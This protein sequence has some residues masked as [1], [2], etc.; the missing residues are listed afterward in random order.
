M[1]G[2]KAVAPQ[3]CQVAI[4]TLDARNSM[5]FYTALL[6]LEATGH[7]QVQ[8]QKA[9]DLF[10]MPQVRAVNHW[11][12][13][14]ERF[15]QL[16]LF[17]FAHS[18]R[19]RPAPRTEGGYARLFVGVDEIGSTLTR[20]AQAGF[21]QS[22]NAAETECVLH[23]PDGT[24]VH[25]TPGVAVGAGARIVGVGLDVDDLDDALR[26]FNQALGLPLL[27][28]VPGG[29]GGTRPEG[30]RLDAGQHWIE[31]RH[32]PGVGASAPLDAPGLMNIALGL[33][34]PGQFKARYRRVLACGFRS[35]T[36]PMGGGLSH[37]VYLRS[38]QG[39]SVELLQLPAWMDSIW[40]FRAPGPV[41][42]IARALIARL[43][44]R[45]S[46][47]EAG[48]APGAAGTTGKP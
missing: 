21:P 34:R 38:N 18:Y 25:L 24:P 31:L 28:A 46:R 12:A 43:V 13:G 9:A 41:A 22:Q 20:L 30:W 32:R 19:A 8:G 39:I 23:D 6:G 47:A 40:G 7:F 36:P 17:E 5:R 27:Q 2:L 45:A 35:S 4:C 42:R 10:E 26:Y 33:R 11:L 48:Q 16:E 3:L 29:H 14:G 1:S 44:A 37:V 15:F